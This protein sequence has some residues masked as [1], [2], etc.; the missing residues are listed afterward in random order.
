MRLG[1]LIATLAALL[2][3]S[4]AATASASYTPNPYGGKTFVKPSPYGGKIIRPNPFG[5]RR[6]LGVK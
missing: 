6:F 3:L 5:G 4:L 1:A 2:L